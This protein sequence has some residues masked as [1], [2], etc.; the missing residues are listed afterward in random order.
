MKAYLMARNRLAQ[1]SVTPA[2]VRG[3][4]S[5]REAPNGGD[6]AASTLTSTS[7]GASTMTATRTSN[8]QILE[9]I[10]AQTE[11]INALVGALTGLAQPQVQ[12]QAPVTPTVKPTPAEDTSIDVPKGYMEHMSLKVAELTANDGQER[13][14]YARR[15]GHGETKL[16]YCLKARW[17]AGLRD[18]GLI[19]AIKLF[20]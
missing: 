11:S 6:S 9:A 14:L 15:N 18:R 4:E 1:A 16:A 5:S 3:T 10:N 20:G 12:A 17:D 7:I 19:G 2:R 13:V 8:K